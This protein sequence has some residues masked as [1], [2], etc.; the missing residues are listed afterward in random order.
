ML[1][2]WPY[3]CT[4]RVGALRTM[5]RAKHATQKATG[6]N[7]AV[8]RTLSNAKANRLI[9]EALL[10]PEQNRTKEL[11]Y[12]RAVKVP[13]PWTACMRSSQ[14]QQNNIATEQY[15]NEQPQESLF[16]SFTISDL[17]MAPIQQC[18]PD[19]AFTTLDVICPD[20]LG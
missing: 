6:L 9:G 1:E 10:A 20:L 7:F 11:T 5:T 17:C 19:E 12:Q 16:Y 14:Q 4:S 2:L 3:P 8:N 13:G 15:S 18:K